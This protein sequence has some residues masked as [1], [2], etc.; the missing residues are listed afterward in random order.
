MRDISN[1]KHYENVSIRLE[2]LMFPFQAEFSAF[3][4]PSQVNEDNSKSDSPFAFYHQSKR[5]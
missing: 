1:Y 5:S 4:A 3:V 2:M